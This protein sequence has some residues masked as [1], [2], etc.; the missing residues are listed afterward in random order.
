MQSLIDIPAEAVP[1][2]KLGENVVH[3]ARVL[4]AAGMQVGP[5]KVLD[6]LNALQ[7]GIDISRRRL[8][9]GAGSDFRAAP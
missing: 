1:G 5:A 3:F 9:F 8:A 4:R 2:G 6:A 7:I